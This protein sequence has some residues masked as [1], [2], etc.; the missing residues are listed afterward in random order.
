MLTCNHFKIDLGGEGER[1]RGR[2]GGNL[3]Q[4]FLENDHKEQ[5]TEPKT[6]RTKTRHPKR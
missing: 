6:D 2:G 5:P 3:V 1:E 4:Q